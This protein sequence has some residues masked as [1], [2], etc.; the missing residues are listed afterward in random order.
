MDYVV[1]Y[2]PTKDTDYSYEKYADILDSILE[3][4]IEKEKGLEINTGGLRSGLKSTNPCADLLKRY[5]KLGGEIIT[6]GSDAHKTADVSSS[7]EIAR[8][9]LLDCGFKY[10]TTFEKRYAEFHRIV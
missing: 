2:G 8:E 9:I 3:L 6:I 4:L 7:F 5:K 10:Y 1:R